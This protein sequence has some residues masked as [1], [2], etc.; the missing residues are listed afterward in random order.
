MAGEAGLEY[1]I[2]N[3]MQRRHRGIE[4]STRTERI[5]SVSN[6]QFLL[7][8]DDR[9]SVI[10][11]GYA[12]SGPVTSWRCLSPVAQASCR[13]QHSTRFLHLQDRVY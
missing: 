2:A 3:P 7:P 4:R 11:R 1:Y 10:S 12:E 6:I 9:R 5:N 8:Y 13:D